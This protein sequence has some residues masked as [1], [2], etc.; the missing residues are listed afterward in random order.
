MGMGVQT[1]RCQQH[2]YAGIVKYLPDLSGAEG[3]NHDAMCALP[4]KTDCEPLQVLECK[5]ADTSIQ[6]MYLSSLVQVCVT[7]M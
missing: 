5:V 4:W 2:A 7:S 1:Q 6:D 3:V